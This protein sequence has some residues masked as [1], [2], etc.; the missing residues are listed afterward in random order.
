MLFP[1]QPGSCCSWGHSALKYCHFL[2]RKRLVKEVAS[3]LSHSADQCNY[4]LA[5]CSLCFSSSDILQLEQET[6]L[7]VE[8]LLMLCSQDS[9]PS[10]QAA[11]KVRHNHNNSWPIT[12]TKSIFVNFV[13]FYSVIILVLVITAVLLCPIQTGLTSLVKLLKSRPHLSQSAVEFLLSQLHLSCDSSRVLMCHSL[14]AI[15]T[16]LPVLGDG[17]LGD[18]VDLYRVASHSST[19]KQ[20]ELLVSDCAGSDFAC[21]LLLFFFSL[22]FDSYSICHRF[23]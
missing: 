21:A 15:A 13:L 23:P 17:M 8:S 3:I 5:T 11:L 16:H 14:A 22:S 4:F 19:D 7:G 2:S 12:D 20:Q 6:V 1:Q 18:L 9:S 10:A